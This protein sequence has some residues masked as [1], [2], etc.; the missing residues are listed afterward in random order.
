MKQ[1]K[2][3]DISAAATE[4][5]EDNAPN[6]A[7]VGPPVPLVKKLGRVTLN[8]NRPIF[9]VFRLDSFDG[10]ELDVALPLSDAKSERT[11]LKVLQDVG[12]E[13]PENVPKA[14]S[15]VSR[16]VESPPL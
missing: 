14:K 8:G 4:A 6:D 11:V 9:D 12:A 2:K 1:L 3:P 13:L 7:A 16:L 15:L 5:V 10:K